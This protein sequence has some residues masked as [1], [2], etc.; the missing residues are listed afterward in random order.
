MI[1]KRSSVFL[2]R[3][4]DGAAIA[5]LAYASYLIYLSLVSSYLIW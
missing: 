2:N 3:K 5:K 4:V 1:W